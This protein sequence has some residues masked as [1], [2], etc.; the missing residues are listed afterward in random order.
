MN[1]KLL[2]AGAFLSLFSITSFA[3]DEEV[4]VIGSLIKGTPID[5]GSPISTFDAASIASQ[6]N[7]NIVELIKM[8]PGSSG[9]DGESNQFGSNAAEGVSNINMRGLGTNR[10]LVLINGK[11]QVTVPIRSGAGRSVN[12]HDLPMGA[13]SRIEILKEGAAATYGSDAIAGVVNFIT[14]S[15][16]EGLKFNLGAKPQPGADSLGSEFSI[17]YG[18]KIA[19]D[20]NFLLSLGY[21]NKSQ[22]AAKNTDHSIRS[23]ISNP[24]GGWSTLGNPATLVVPDAGRGVVSAAK[25]FLGGFAAVADPGCNAAGG[26]QSAVTTP[27]GAPITATM[28]ADRQFDGWCRYQYTYFDNVQ[29]DQE[30]TQLWMEF[31][32]DVDGHDYH[33]EFAYGLTDV[34]NWATSPAYPPNDP[35]GN[36]VPNFHPGYQ[37]LLTDFPAL[38]TTMAKTEYLDPEAGPS[39]AHRVRT[40]A[41]GAGGNPNGNSNGA[42]IEFREYD[43]YRFAFSFEGDLSDDI[44]YSTSLNYS[45]SEGSISSSDTQ[46]HK[47]L[48]SLWGYGGPNCNVELTALKTGTGNLTPT[49]RDKTTKSAISASEVANASS[50]TRT[51]CQYLNPFSNAIKQGIAPYQGAQTT[52]QGVASN[53]LGLTFVAPAT[54]QVDSVGVGGNVGINPYYEESLSNSAAFLDWL[55][56]RRITDTES[57]LL[58]ADFTMQ[59][60]LGALAGGEAAWAFGYERRDY[61]IN[62]ALRPGNDLHD[63]AKYPCVTPAE[64]ETQA[65]RDACASSPVGLFM[66]L[67]PTYA[68]D[69]DQSTDSLF[70]EFAL[71][72]LDEFDMQLA[73]RYEDYGTKDSVDPKVVMRW[74]PMDSVT[75]RF[76]GQTTFRAAHPDE[77]S[78]TQVTQLAY[79]SQTGAFKAVDIY[80]NLNLDPEEATTFNVGVI[81]DFGTDNWTMTLDYYDFVIDNPIISESYAQLA[82]AFAAGDT[83]AQGATDA[84]TAAETAKRA[85]VGSQMYGGTNNAQWNAATNNFGSKQIGRIRTNFVN[86]PEIQ[87]NGLDLFVKYDTDYANGTL[88]AGLEANWIL[89]YSVDSYVKGGQ[90]LAGAYECAGYF[91]I[92]NTCR[93]MP[94]L[95]AKAFVNYISGKHNFY[96]ALNHINAYDDRRVNTEIQAHTTLDAN[97]TYSFSDQVSLTFSA[98]NLTDELPPLVFFDMSYDP[99]THSPLGRFLKVGFTYMMD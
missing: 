81:T 21:Q 53:P 23:Y 7:L 64:N 20:A 25:G 39:N 28:S 44:Q 35:W 42:E 95:K 14:D 68:E 76:T 56:D 22:I 94:E 48:A 86:G 15:N 88:S 31:N 33:V 37:Q 13:L 69:Q 1:K 89:K 52:T 5:T 10:T 11:R 82:A 73:L 96:G 32:G 12:L 65:G 26:Y 71:P 27:T 24:L 59:G 2:L 51:G 9:M 54:Q 98:Y 4:T 91:N 57:S 6:N 17:T 60:S 80:G 62:V 16:F 36:N 83:V 38:A 70:A 3:Q 30:N 47:F 85:A 99:T 61:N 75:L 45:L 77:M 49:F 66:F 92:N 78:Q 46:H 90:T 50:T 87:T 29:E 63:G 43:T 93:S 84:P 72:I 34:P 79:V 67:A 18:T 8:V 97:Y 41:M 58:T 55:I 74:S 19:G 40:R